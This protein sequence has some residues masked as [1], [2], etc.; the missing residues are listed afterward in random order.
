MSASAAF[1]RIIKML[2]DCA[3]GYEVRLATHSRVIHFGGK[4]YRSFPK[5]DTVEHGHTRKMVRYLEISRDC[6]AEHLPEVFRS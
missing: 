1:A 5:S 4:V 3:P 6:A 2:N